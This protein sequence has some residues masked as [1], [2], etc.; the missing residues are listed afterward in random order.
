ME[1]MTGYGRAEAAAGELRIVAE[2][3]SVNNRG[4]DIRTRVPSELNPWEPE[5]RRLAR[6]TFSRGSVQVNI[7]LEG[8]AREAAR[9]DHAAARRLAAELTKIKNEL[10]LPGV[11][12]LELLCRFPQMLQP[13]PGRP[14]EAA[15][16]Q[17]AEKAA[18]KAL[19]ALKA[20]R[21][22][23]GKAIG[24]DIREHAAALASL[25]AVIR[26][27]A[28]RALRQLKEGFAGRVRELT[29][30]SRSDSRRVDEEA[31]LTAA[32]RDFTEEMNRL[33]THLAAL[34]ALLAQD[35]PIGRNLEFLT[36]EILRELTT[37]ASKAPGDEIGGL[38]VKARVELEKIREQSYNLE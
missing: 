13:P 37:I 10:D 30:N 38:T 24:G 2:A 9:L 7:S 16:G 23:E 32:R 22:R 21:K 26:K 6:E 15:L 28:P 20:S 19:A 18:R 36:Q 3:R 29:G 12:D 11:V 17:A 31:A 4:L 14:D 34:R 1:S 8:A 33:R 27:S 35:G 25:T 5:L